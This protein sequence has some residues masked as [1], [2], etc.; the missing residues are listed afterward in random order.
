MLKF[1]G[2]LRCLFSPVYASIRPRWCLGW[3][4]CVA[5]HIMMYPSGIRTCDLHLERVIST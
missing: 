2:F 3:C 1:S 4:H 5:C